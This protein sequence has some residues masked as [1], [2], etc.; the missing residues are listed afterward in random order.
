MFGV[1]S[2]H[3]IERIRQLYVEYGIDRLCREAID[4]YSD[5]A[6]KSVLATDL[7][8]DAKEFFVDIARKSRARSK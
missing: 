3:K 8:A 2:D 4:Y 7:P 6:E 1:R 5:M